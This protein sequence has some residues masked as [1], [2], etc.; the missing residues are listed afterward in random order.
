MSHREER[1]FRARSDQLAA[2]TGFVAEFCESQCVDPGDT[3]RLT[4]IVEELFTNTLM[5]GHGADSEAPVLVA[6]RASPTHVHLL[7]ADDAPLFDP[8]QHLRDTPP[9]PELHRD[10]QGGYGLRL[11]VE[12]VESF[13]YA[14]EGRFNRMTLV[15]RR[16]S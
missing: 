9:D 5:H 4:L 7:Y 1:I 6:L 15:L 10:R 13:G 3:L 14:H 12:M 11:V 2:A 16:S 8:L